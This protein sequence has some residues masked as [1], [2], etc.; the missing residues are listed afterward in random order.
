MAG[1]KGMKHFCLETKLLAVQM[2]H[3][4]RYTQKRLLKNCHY[5]EKS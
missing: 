3:E 2:Y 5:L 4:Q 1:K